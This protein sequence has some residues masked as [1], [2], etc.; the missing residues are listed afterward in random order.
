MTAFGTIA[1]RVLCS[2]V[3]SVG[4]VVGKTVSA[5]QGLRA[6]MDAR[7]GCAPP[8]LPGMCDG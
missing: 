1:R 8:E 6:D 7:L 4:L 3:R 5:L 2:Q